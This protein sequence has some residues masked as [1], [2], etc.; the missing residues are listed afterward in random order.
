M[1]S[2]G[3]MNRVKE[4]IFIVVLSVIMIVVHLLPILVNANPFSELISTN[5]NVEEWREWL[6]SMGGMTNE[7]SDL[8]KKGL[9][10]KGKAKCKKWNNPIPNEILGK[11]CEDICDLKEEEHKKVIPKLNT[12][13]KVYQTPERIDLLFRDVEF[14]LIEFPETFHSGMGHFN[15]CR[16]EK[17][18]L[19]SAKEMWFVFFE[20]D[21]IVFTMDQEKDGKRKYYMSEKNSIVRFGAKDKFSIRRIPDLIDKE[22]RSIVGIAYIYELVQDKE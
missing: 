10:M 3:R 16:H 6:T 4:V 21:N 14:Y 1:Y 20:D 17:G 22:G 8:G 11:V 18:E 7:N 5:T 19:V 2:L 15:Y 12:E 9:L 13:V